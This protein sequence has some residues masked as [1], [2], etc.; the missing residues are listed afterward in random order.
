MLRKNIQQQNI[1]ILNLQ[2]EKLIQSAG[3]TAVSLKFAMEKIQELNDVIKDLK[4][5][6]TLKI[7]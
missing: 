3:L 1:T 5:K 4:S 6:E 7:Y 2:E